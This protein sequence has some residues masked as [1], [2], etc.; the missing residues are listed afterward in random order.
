[1]LQWEGKINPFASDYPLHEFLQPKWCWIYIFCMT[2]MLFSHSIRDQYYCL[3]FPPLN[4]CTTYGETTVNSEMG[5][6]L[7]PLNLINR[8]PHDPLQWARIRR[9]IRAQ[10][11]TASFHSHA[12][13]ILSYMYRI[14]LRLLYTMGFKYFINL[15]PSLTVWPL[16]NWL[17]PSEARII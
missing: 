12:I 8:I 7:L 11:Y 5:S 2:I 4:A 14:P 17:S 3:E 13:L 16:S 9:H 10:R 6:T 15:K 1:M